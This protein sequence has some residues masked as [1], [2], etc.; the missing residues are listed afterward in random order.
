LV[1]VEE[2]EDEWSG[3]G[4]EG[5][6]EETTVERNGK[7]ETKDSLDNHDLDIFFEAEAVERKDET[8]KYCAQE[9]GYNCQEGFD[10]DVEDVFYDMEDIFDYQDDEDIYY[11]LEDKAER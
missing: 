3:E 2:R 8:D 9:G 7:E 1:T 4:V 6:H 11:D 5:A 10:E